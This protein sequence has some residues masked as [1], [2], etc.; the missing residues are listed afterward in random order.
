MEENKSKWQR[1]R[2]RLGDTY[3][4]IVMDEDSFEEVASY[5][6]TLKNIYLLISSV[7]VILAFV[8]VMLIAF[9]PLRQYLPGGGVAA[10]VAQVNKAYKKIAELEE[11]VEAYETYTNSI[12]KIL[13][14]N[15]ETEDDV[16]TEITIDA[17]TL[18]EVSVSEETQALREELELEKIGEQAESNPQALEI[19]NKEASLEQVS[20]V[21]PVNG[22]VSAAFNA[23]NSHFGVDILAPKNTAIKAAADGVVFLSDWT[24]ETGN[25]IG[26]QHA[27]N[28]ITFYKHNSMLLKEAGDVVRAGEVVA[29]IGNTGTL[30]SGPHL[31]FELW[32]KTKAMNPSDYISF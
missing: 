2:E 12:K 30:S 29:I 8:I 22:K 10:D 16:A 5:K 17:D 23:Q 25:T 31:H 1:F 26:I 15:V 24:L 6:L 4:L 13:S 20:F 18:Q 7:L 27:N 19:N 32:Y 3:R 28:I 11:E 21:A 14:G 9:T